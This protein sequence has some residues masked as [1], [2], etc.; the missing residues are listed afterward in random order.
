MRVNKLLE[1]CAYSLCR[2]M[3]TVNRYIFKT[4]GELPKRFN[5]ENLKCNNHKKDVSWYCIKE[6]I[7]TCSIWQWKKKHL[8]KIILFIRKYVALWH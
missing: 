7:I 1:Q 4:N 3:K 8:E 6:H 2:C 5:F